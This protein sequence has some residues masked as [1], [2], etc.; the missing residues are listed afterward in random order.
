VPA[1]SPQRSAARS[2][3]C[4][5]PPLE[6]GSSSRPSAD[7]PAPRRRSTSGRRAPSPARCR[8]ATRR[9]S[10]QPQAVPSARKAAQV[11]PSAPP[12]TRGG[13]QP[14][15]EQRQREE[16]RNEPRAR[17]VVRRRSAGGT[18]SRPGTSQAP[19][20]RTLSPQRRH[21][22]SLPC[23]AR[24]SARRAGP[25]SPRVSSRRRQG[26]LH[27]LETEATAR[28][29][30]CPAAAR[31]AGRR[32]GSAPSR[33]P[34]PDTERRQGV[35]PTWRERLHHV[36]STEVE[37]ES[38]T[39]CTTSCSSR[40][41][42]SERPTSRPTFVTWKPQVFAHDDIALSRRRVA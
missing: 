6:F 26:Q 3:R 21:R 8:R 5:S 14:E 24:R 35:P 11:M 19:P 41:H 30:T 29:S 28:E 32:S 31:R 2:R 18:T 34:V 40:R 13:S 9:R 36:D 37:R 33:R 23:P 4:S 20:S 22:L 38:F 17:L 27:R 10:P 25:G 12:W 15:A 16:R 1:A 39:H 7:P 42:G